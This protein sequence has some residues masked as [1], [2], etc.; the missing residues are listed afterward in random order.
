MMEFK[1]KTVLVTGA[2]SGIGAG[3]C[4]RLAREG[5][6]LAML[7]RREEN[8]LRL[9]DELKGFGSELLPLRCD[10]SSRDEIKSA[11]AE[12]KSRFGPVDVA[13]LNA[14]VS[15]G[16]RLCDYDL[17]AARQIFDVNVFGILHFIGELLPDFKARKSGLIVGV[18]SLADARGF[19]RNGFYSASKTAVTSLLESLR[20]EMKAHGITVITVR[21]GFVRTEMTE[22]N[23][24]PM[25]FIMSPEKA[26]A[27]IFR[28]MKNEKRMI[29][30][31]WP[32]ALGARAIRVMP[33]FL[34]ETIAPKFRK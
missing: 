32:S 8:L 9:A 13:V 31:P 22:K 17:E 6:K 3:L 18:S 19:P 29:S 16:S 1:G 33:R 23:T 11:C 27:I 2:S 20:V 7:A 10:V 30:F 5:V 24:I 14:A 21:P 26:A 15:Y 34:Y 28:G 4:R 12:I 25:P